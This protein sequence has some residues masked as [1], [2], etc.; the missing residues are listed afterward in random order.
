MEGLKQTWPIK[1]KI[2]ERE[3]SP[4]R[5]TC[6]NNGEKEHF[7]TGCTRPKRKQNHKSEDD[8]DSISSIED[9]RDTLILSVDNLIELWILDSGASFHSSPNKERFEISNLKIL[10]W[11]I[12]PTTKL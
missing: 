7:R 12:L 9:N 3:K 8:N 1:I 5:P 4:N 6:W 11:R 2:K 10:I